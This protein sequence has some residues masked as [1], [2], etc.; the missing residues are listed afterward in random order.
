MPGTVIEPLFITDPFEGSI[1]SSTHGQQVL[2]GGI[3]AGIEQFFAPPA[4]HHHRVK[5]K[6]WVPASG[7]LRTVPSRPVAQTP[8]HFRPGRS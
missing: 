8:A 4:V 3:A 5:T 1:A 2:A 7:A 6:A